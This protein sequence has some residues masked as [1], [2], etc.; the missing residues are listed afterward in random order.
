MKSSPSQREEE[1]LKAV[2]LDYLDSGEPVGSRRLSK[3]YEL[4]L[5]SATIRNI[6]SDLDDQG[7]LFQP[8]T[9]AGRVPTQR[10]FR[11][12]VDTILK[13]CDLTPPEKREIKARLEPGAKEIPRLL[14]KASR[15]L[16]NVSGHIAL[17]GAPKPNT[18]ILKHIDFLKL[19]P[20]LN[21]VIFVTEGGIVQN[22]L[23]EAE[24]ELSQG[25]LDKYANYLNELLK[26]LP[27]PQV[28][29]RI[30]E[31]LKKDKIKFDRL[32]SKALA[33]SRKAFQE[34]P[35]D[36]LYVEGTQHLFKYPEFADLQIMEQLFQALQEKST[37]LKLLDQSLHAQGVQIFIGSETHFKSMESLSLITTS[38]R[39]A[40]YPL[41]T[42]GVIGP[43]RMDYAKVIPIV[44]FTAKMISSVMDEQR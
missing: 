37:L 31:E 18:V 40:S 30:M 32:L 22:R 1:I 9:S 23:L 29:K 3:R 24:E 43:M 33:I 26:D 25:E 6:M 19:R 17:V 35:E 5:S 38:Y 11:Y 39:K 41:G 20:G 12:Y 44:D 36:E 21:L 2:I 16:A 34:D 7:Y 14:Q 8:H 15:I 4:N 13:V 27:L 10:G 28:R 42:L